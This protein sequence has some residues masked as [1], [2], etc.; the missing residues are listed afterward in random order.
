MSSSSLKSSGSR[1]ASI[2]KNVVHLTEDNF[3]RKVLDS[4]ELYLVNFF[5]PWCGYSQRLIPN[6]EEAAGQIHNAKLGEVDVTVFKKLAQKY[7][8]TQYPTIKIFKPKHKSTPEEYH[9]PRDTEGIV[10]YIQNLSKTVSPRLSPRYGSWKKGPKGGK[11]CIDARSGRKV[12]CKR[13]RRY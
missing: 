6:W 4:D 13:P 5:A 11:F 9:G 3:K 8:I 2:H 12:Y 1:S 10:Q 7:G